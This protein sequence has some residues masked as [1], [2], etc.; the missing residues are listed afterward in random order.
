VGIGWQVREG[1]II[2]ILRIC[3]TAMDEYNQWFA[4]SQIMFAF[5]EKSVSLKS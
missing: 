1:F 5:D 4:G 3:S 2:E